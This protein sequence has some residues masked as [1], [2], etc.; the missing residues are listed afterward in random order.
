MAVCVSN[1]HIVSFD[2]EQ[3]VL[4]DS[5][6]RE[7]GFC[8]KSEVH[9]GEGQLHRAF[10]LFVFNSSGELIIQKRAAN[11]QLW[12][13][14]WS[15]TCC[16]HPRRGESMDV[17]IQRRLREEIGIHASLT[18]LFKFQYQA[19]F[20]VVGAENELCWVYVGCSDDVPHANV[21]EVSGIRYLAPRKLD[22]EMNDDP[23]KFSPWFKLEW[24]RIRRD[25][26]DLMAG[27]K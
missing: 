5:D 2:D 1:D 24:M 23:D 25:Y 27:G 22:K 7:I 10:S 11:K 19:R 3:L 15:N 21:S 9:K 8:S 13:G 18:F 20:G 6:D 16:S 12:P 14:Y 26:P 4:V 17:A